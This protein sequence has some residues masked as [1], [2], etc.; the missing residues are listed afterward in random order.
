MELTGIRGRRCKQLLDDLME[1]RG[2]WKL[3]EEVLDSIQWIIRFGRGYGRV[4][5]Q[6][7]E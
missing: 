7:A 6:I 5:R 2:Y 3:K 4:V 1:M